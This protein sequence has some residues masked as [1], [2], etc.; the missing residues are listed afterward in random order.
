VDALHPLCAGLSGDVSIDTGSQTISYFTASSVSSGAD[1]IALSV[2]TPANG[3]FA[4]LESGQPG[5]DG[6]TWTARRMAL[7]CHEN[8]DPNLVTVDGWKLL[9]GAVAYALTPVPEPGS[10]ALLRLGMTFLVGRRQRGS[11]VFLSTS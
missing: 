6:N 7:P 1:I 9:D 10:P 2:A 5:K 4:V 11:R 3:V 8:W